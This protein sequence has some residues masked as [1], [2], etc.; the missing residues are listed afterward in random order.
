MLVSHRHRFIFVKTRKS[1]GSSVELAFEPFARPEGS[2]PPGG[3]WGFATE[4]MVTDAGVV[5]YQDYDD[6]VSCE[7]S[8]RT[9]ADEIAY[10]GWTFDNTAE[11]RIP[12]LPA[13]AA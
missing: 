11:P 8:A 12:G 5:G 1:A 10:F 6:D 4:E 7:A 13:R 3:E 9:Y 2:T